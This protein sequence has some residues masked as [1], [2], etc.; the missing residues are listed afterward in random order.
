[1]RPSPT[2]V[3]SAA[4]LLV[5]LVTPV[6]AVTVLWTNPGTGIWND[7][8][9]WNSNSIP[10]ASDEGRINNGG[11]AVIDDTQVV[12]TLFAIVADVTGTTGTL[13]MTGGRLETGS[14]IRIGGNGG[15][16]TGGTGL[17]EQSGGVVRLNG[18]NVNI[19]FGGTAV[20]TYNLSGGSL[21]V[22]AGFI[23]AVGNLGSGTLNQTGG[24][25]YIR[26]ATTPA[27]SVI[28]LGRNS[29]TAP[30][31]GSYTLSGGIAA[32]RSF[33]FGRQAQT[34]GTLS[35]VN[36]FNLQGTGTLITNGVRVQNTAAVNTFNFTGGTLVADSIGLSLTNSGGTLRPDFADFTGV[37]LSIE[38]I[39]VNR[40]STLTFGAGN[41]YIQTA[42]GTLAVDIGAAGNDLVSLGGG[43]TTGT[44]TLAG[45]VAVSLVDSFNPPAGSFFDVLIASSITSTAQITGTTPAGLGFQQSIA[46]S[47][48]G[49]ELLR[50]TV[51]PEPTTAA[52]AACGLVALGGRR[53]RRN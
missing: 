16:A 39:P 9:N 35:S 19:G 34:S 4:A 5:L 28:Q 37:P 41:N 32:A 1:M 33:D 14:D 15:A 44:A 38:A 46:S 22:E 21:Q 43:L 13:R 7:P 3:A 49:R 31:S 30:A 18:G 24:S 20:G 23:A 47:P 11:T 6:Q 52:I 29:A 2:L 8:A 27:N 17:F 50:L 42:T 12:T 48:D 25:I 10:T 53:F 51:V 45:T 26:S 36:T 40:I